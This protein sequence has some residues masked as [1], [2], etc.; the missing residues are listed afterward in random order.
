MP[1]PIVDRIAAEVA[2]ITRDPA[3]RT[4]LAEIGVDPT[5]LGPEE[6]SAFWDSEMATWGPIVRGSG[7]RVE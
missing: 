4:R 7:A 6:F 2:R 1:R 5:G 3:C